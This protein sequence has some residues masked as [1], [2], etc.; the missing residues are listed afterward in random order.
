VSVCGRTQSRLRRLPP[1]MCPARAAS[2][3]PR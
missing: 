2:G 1:G 3:F